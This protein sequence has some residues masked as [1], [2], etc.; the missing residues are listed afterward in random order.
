MKKAP[1]KL[2][3][4][5]LRTFSSPKQKGEASG[6]GDRHHTPKKKKKKR[7]KERERK[8]ELERGKRK[9]NSDTYKCMQKDGRALCSSTRTLA[10]V[11][12]V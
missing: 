12:R 7:K 2:S 11:D 5:S 4:P 10:V 1:T 6:G 8:R 9:R 3:R